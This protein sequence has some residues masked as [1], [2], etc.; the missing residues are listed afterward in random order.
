[1][2]ISAGEE[3]ITWEFYEVFGP[4]LRPFHGRGRAFLLKKFPSMSHST[5]KGE[6]PTLGS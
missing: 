5:M 4:T 2:N 3:L 1:M 6:Y